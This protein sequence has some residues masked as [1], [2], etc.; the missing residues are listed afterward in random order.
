[1]QQSVRGVLAALSLSAALVLTTAAPANAAI[2]VTLTPTAGMV[3]TRVDVLASNCNEDATGDVESTDVGFKLPK[4][5]NNAQGSFIVTEKM[6]PGTY[7]VAVTCGSDTASA[8][9]T[10][11]SGAGAST[12]G[13][14]TASQAATAVLWSG[15]ALVV[16]A[17]AGLWLLRRRS[18]VPNGS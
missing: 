6:R 8:K 17:A 5:D 16:A 14:S 1:M 18:I 2:T 9:F 11:T 3:G 15:A 13:G 10:V 4:G 7:T 12:G